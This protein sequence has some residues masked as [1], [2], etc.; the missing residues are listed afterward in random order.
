MINLPADKIIG[1]K[2][3]TVQELID[4]LSSLPDDAKHKPANLYICDGDNGYLS[5]GFS[6]HFN[7]QHEVCLLGDRVR[8]T[9]LQYNKVK[10]YLQD[11]YSISDAVQE[12]LCWSE[13]EA[14]DANGTNWDDV[15]EEIVTDSDWED[16]LNEALGG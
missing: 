13:E 10:D 15:I 16:V 4:V 12:F 14:K 2:E 6:I 5:T 3:Y 7:E 8:Y 9:T 1:H 11:N